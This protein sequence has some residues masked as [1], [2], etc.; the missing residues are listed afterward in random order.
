MPIVQLEYGEGDILA[1]HGL[2]VHKAKINEHPTRWRRVMYNVYVKQYE[3]FWPGWTS[4]RRL[5]ER[6]DSP[7]YQEGVEDENEK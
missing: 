5:L 6:Y 1:V 3:P 4:G 2:L 7:L